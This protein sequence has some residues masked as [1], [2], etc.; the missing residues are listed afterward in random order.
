MKLLGFKGVLFVLS[1][2]F[3]ASKASQGASK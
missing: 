3:R 2:L 1:M